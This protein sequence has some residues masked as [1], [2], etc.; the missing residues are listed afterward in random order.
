MAKNCINPRCEK[1]IPSSA[2]FCLFCGTQQVENE[3]LSEEEKQRIEIKEMQET[4]QL[5]KNAL[6]NAQLTNDSSVE[7]LQK[8]DNIQCQ[9]SM[10]QQQIVEKSKVKETIS[11]DAL[12]NLFND[13][14]IRVF[15]IVAGIALVVVV[16]ILIIIFIR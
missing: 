11:S 5:L 13:K 14:W 8:I 16:L 10:L 15:S 2:T 1:E 4:I 6:S 9:L 7:N 12:R 3:N